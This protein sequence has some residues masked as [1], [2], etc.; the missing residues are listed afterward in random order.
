[1]EE[2]VDLLTGWAHLGHWYPEDKGER[3][4]SWAFWE[5]GGVGN[6]TLTCCV[7]LSQHFPNCM[8]WEVT[9]VL[10]KVRQASP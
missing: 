4:L 2:V 1:M 8:P 10:L 3:G 5:V 6:S 7:T 9:R